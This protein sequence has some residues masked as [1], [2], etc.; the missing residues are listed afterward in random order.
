MRRGSRIPKEVVQPG[1]RVDVLWEWTPWRAIRRRGDLWTNPREEARTTGQE[2][3]TS[4]GTTMG[5][6]TAYQPE[7]EPQDRVASG[8]TARRST[9]RAFIPNQ[10]LRARD[11]GPRRQRRWQPPSLEGHGGQPR[12]PTSRDIIS[13]FPSSPRAPCLHGVKDGEQEGSIP[14]R[15]GRSESGDEASQEAESLLGDG[16]PR[17][18]WFPPGRTHPLIGTPVDPRTPYPA[19]RRAFPGAILEGRALQP[20]SERRGSCSAGAR[21]AARKRSQTGASRAIL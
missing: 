3:G 2:A 5:R 13:C 21:Q 8:K 7:F 10:D 15:N 14:S 9:G 4:W 20:R 6:R 19:G 16:E 11:D 12:R 17:Q 18:R 1:N